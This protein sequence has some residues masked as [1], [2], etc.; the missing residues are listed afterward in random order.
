MMQIHRIST[1][2]GEVKH[3]EQV[4]HYDSRTPVMERNDVFHLISNSNYVYAYLY[5]G[6][7]IFQWDVKERRI[8]HQLDISKLAPCSES[9]MSISIEEQMS[10]DNC[11]VTCMSLLQNEMFVSTTLGCLVVI[12]S[13]SLRPI[14]VFRP[15]EH[16]IKAIISYHDV[17]HHHQQ[18]VSD[19]KIS[20]AS[21]RSTAS[22]E[23]DVQQGKDLTA[24]AAARSFIVTIGKG[25][26]NLMSRY[27]LSSMTA[28]DMSQSETFYAILWNTGSWQT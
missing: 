4:T 16:E 18:Q 26:R 23:M 8:L 7:L 11:Q 22:Q 20:S 25:C 6:C 12:E 2:S 14:T 1:T 19:R 3:K 27:V 17:Y 13:Q 5:P 24:A 28:G 9:L 21:S 10:A 15:H